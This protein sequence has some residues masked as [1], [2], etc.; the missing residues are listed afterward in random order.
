MDIDDAVQHLIDNY[1][2]KPEQ[3]YKLK[4]RVQHDSNAAQ[5]VKRVNPEFL[6]KPGN[7]RLGR[8]THWENYQPIQYIHLPRNPTPG[9]TSIYDLE[10]KRDFFRYFED[11]FSGLPDG[12][13]SA[14]ISKGRKGFAWLFVLEYRD[15]EVV[16]W[17]Q[18]SNGNQY[19]N[20]SSYLG[21]PKYFKLR[22]DW[23]V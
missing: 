5:S 23:N 3:K 22:D 11:K 9:Y 17:K 15:G 19:E 20:S 16:W 2:F 13:Y 4:I 1:Y 18:K 8:D 10:T 12:V 21:F 7:S 6:D 14:M